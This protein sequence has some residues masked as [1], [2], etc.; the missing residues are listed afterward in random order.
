MRPIK[1]PFIYPVIAKKLPKKEDLI[2]TKKEDYIKPDKEDTPPYKNIL[3]IQSIKKKHMN[4]NAPVINYRDV[5]SANIRSEYIS[6]QEAIK[7]NRI[8]KMTQ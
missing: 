1:S 4:K 7:K 3:T 2:F 5:P 6:I 8:K